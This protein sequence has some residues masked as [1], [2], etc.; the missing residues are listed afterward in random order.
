MPDIQLA[1][2]AFTLEEL[3][4]LKTLAKRKEGFW[5]N[6]P[7]LVSILAFLLSLTTA[8]LSAYASYRKD[9]NDQ[10]S[11]LSAAIQTIQDL[12]LK[13]I[14][15]YE[16]YRNTP[17]AMQAGGLLAGQANDTMRIARDLAFS[18]GTH[19]SAGALL[20]VGGSV[21]SLGDTAAAETLYQWALNAS[22][23]SLDEGAALRALG[24]IKVRAAKSGA[25]VQEGEELFLRAAN[26]ERKYPALPADALLWEKAATQVFWAGA[27]AP[28]HC[29]EARKH[30]RE[31]VTLL[32]VPLTNLNLTQLRDSVRA[33]S[34]TGI[35]GV[36]TCPLE[37]VT[38]PRQ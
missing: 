23:S 9:I 32:Q 21:H 10:L 20:V 17:Y 24:F 4:A 36:A 37:P 1:T 7:L 14:E 26:L 22:R 33:E 18:L 2:E 6:Y 3:A 30:F 5:K 34:A 29:D 38:P 27:L 12:N 11:R 35:G 8:G 15:I 19:A 25:S 31:A 16:R 28:S 13:Q